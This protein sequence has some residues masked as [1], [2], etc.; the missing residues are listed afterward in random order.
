MKRLFSLLC[1]II[2]L[3]ISIPTKAEERTVIQIPLPISEYYISSENFSLGFE[4]EFSNNNAFLIL[5]NI[6]FNQLK[7]LENDLMI[8][9]LSEMRFYHGSD[10]NRYYLGLCYEQYYFKVKECF[11]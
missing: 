10:L 3:F 5:G 9:L 6:R 1:F 4:K 8:D 11:H 2:L 7:D